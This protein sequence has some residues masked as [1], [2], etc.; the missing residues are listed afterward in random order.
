MPLTIHNIINDLPRRPNVAAY[1]LRP[2]SMITRIV[3]HYDAVA[4]P[5][6]KE[7]KEGYDPVARYVSQAKYHIS[8]NWNEGSSAVVHGFG[9]MYHYRI[10]A[11]GRSWL[12]QPENLTLWHARNANNSSIAICC[13]LGPNQAPTP[14]Q[15][16]SLRLLLNHFCYHRP[17]IPAG[18]RDV[19]GHGE[20]LKEGNRT[21]C[22]GA[23]ISFVQAY[24]AGK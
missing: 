22:P 18:R 13:D 5:P 4:V 1:R 15:L 23:L 24:R 12:T 2:L 19:Y 7:G 21:P 3:V 8:K 17:D 10:S 20:L 9:F 14:A 16:N 6:A 11:D